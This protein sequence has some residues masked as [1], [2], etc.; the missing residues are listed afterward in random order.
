[1]ATV[2]ELTVL[3]ADLVAKCNELEQRSS[4]FAARMSY[5]V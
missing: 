3:A 2:K 5:A 1:M 4:N